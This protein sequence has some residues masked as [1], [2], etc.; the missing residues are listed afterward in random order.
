MATGSMC[1]IRQELVMVILI[2]IF[3]GAHY[4]F[5]KNI[6]NIGS[7]KQYAQ[8]FDTD[9][10]PMAIFHLAGSNLPLTLTTLK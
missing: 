6:N 4:V 3:S 2:M 8:H 10:F 1:R 9:N 5:F 7:L